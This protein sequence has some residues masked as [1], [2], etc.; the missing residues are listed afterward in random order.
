MKKYLIAALILQFV[1]S[2]KKATDNNGYDCR[3]AKPV[4]SDFEVGESLGGIFYKTDTIDINNAAYF[5]AAGRFDSLIWKIGDDPRRF[6]TPFI[7]L[8]FSAADAGKTLTAKLSVKGK[9]DINCIPGDKDSVTTAKTFTIVCTDSVNA[10]ALGVAYTKPAF[11]GRWSGADINNPNEKF[12]VSIANFGTDPD[13]HDD[14]IFYGIRIYNLPKGCGGRIDF[15]Q[16]G[17]SACGGTLLSPFFYAYQPNQWGYAGFTLTESPQSGCCPGIKMSGY[18]FKTD[19]IR[20][21]Y[22]VLN[23]VLKKYI[24]AGKR[25]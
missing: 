1:I 22:E 10:V 14:T 2:C 9:P 6:I 8:Q 4:S 25:I 12:T 15:V 11:L 20:I 13:M 24:F 21:E 23:P 18:V 16:P 17:N 19:S 3:N 5:K 7:S